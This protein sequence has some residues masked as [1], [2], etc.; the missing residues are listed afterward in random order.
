MSQDWYDPQ[1]PCLDATDLKEPRTMRR[2]SSQGVS[3]GQE[4]TRTFHLS[5]EEARWLQ[6]RL[7]RFRRLQNGDRDG[8]IRAV[9]AVQP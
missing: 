5:L 7:K 8:R 4:V 9:R 6:N 1:H 3:G 2:L